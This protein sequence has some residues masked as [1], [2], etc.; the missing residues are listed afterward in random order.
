VNRGNHSIEPFGNLAR[1]LLAFE[2]ADEDLSEW[3]NLLQSLNAVGL[4]AR[5]RGRIAY[6]P[7][8]TLRNAGAP[9]LV[10]LEQSSIFRIAGP[11]PVP[12]CDDRSSNTSRSPQ[13]SGLGLPRDEQALVKARDPV[14]QNVIL[15]LW[16]FMAEADDFEELTQLISEAFSRFT[17]REHDIVE[18]DRVVLLGAGQAA[19]YGREREG[20]RAVTPKDIEQS[21]NL[22]LNDVESVTCWRNFARHWPQADSSIFIKIDWGREEIPPALIPQGIAK[23]EPIADELENYLTGRNGFAL[24]R[25]LWTFE[26]ASSPFEDVVGRIS[27]IIGDHSDLR[28]VVVGNKKIAKFGALQSEAPEWLNT[29]CRPAV[30]KLGPG[31]IASQR[32]SL[33]DIKHPL[34]VSKERGNPQ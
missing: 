4:L 12:G 18:S 5:N 7:S 9:D 33:G 17:K 19:Q 13:S 27:E 24:M 25:G 3:R 31:I 16:N 23:T 21:S 6:L 29:F 10:Q 8:P 2:L 30:P 32:P 1:F 20:P 14:P 22:S 34:I 15:G 11:A 28:A 26:G